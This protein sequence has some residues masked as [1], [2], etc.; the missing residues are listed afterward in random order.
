LNPRR[1]NLAPAAAAALVVAALAGSCGRSERAAPPAAAPDS[2]AAARAEAA[3]VVA[4]IALDAV[5]LAPGRTRVA[6]PLGGAD[7]L[8]LRHVGPGVLGDWEARV[9]RADGSGETLEKTTGALTAAATADLHGDGTRDALWVLESGGTGMT[10]EELHLYCARA[11][12]P[13][14]LTLTFTHDAT[15]PVPGQVQSDELERADFVLESALLDRVKRQHGYISDADLAARPD[16]AR[17]AFYFWARDNAG[18]ADGAPM[19]LRRF[20]GRPAFGASAEDS[21]VIGGVSFI[22]YFKGGVIAYDPVADRHWVVFHPKDPYDWPTRLAL[23]GDVLVI[24]TRGEGLALVRLSNFALRRL[25]VPG[26]DSIDSLAVTD[27][28]VTVNGATTVA[29]PRF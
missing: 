13:L 2:L 12:K 7:S 26:Y 6:L 16:D 5:T 29:L 15:Q 14:V 4:G 22:A 21:L 11:R 3:R 9:R 19:K 25:A 23:A 8:V 1:A 18:L 27:S 20:R 28:T 24:G 17:Y 10:I